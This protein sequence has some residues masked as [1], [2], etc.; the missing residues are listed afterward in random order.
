M[1]VGE[2]DVAQVQE[3]GND[4]KQLADLALIETT[5]EQRVE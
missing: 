1:A 3:A 2:V 4:G 5:V